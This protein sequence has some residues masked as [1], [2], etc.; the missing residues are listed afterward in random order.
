MDFHHD[1]GEISRKHLKKLGITMPKDCDDWKIYL[2]WLQL[3]QRRLDTDTHYQVYYSKEL[4]QKLET[5]SQED[6]N[7]LSD[8]ENRLCNAE[9][10]TDYM[11][12]LINSIDMKKSDFLLKVWNIYH[13]HLEKKTRKSYKNP[14]VLFFQVRG[15]AAYFID[16]RQHPTGNEWFSRELLNIVYDNWPELLSYRPGVTP[17]L[18]SGEPVNLTDEEIFVL[19]KNGITTLVPFRDGAIFYT[20]AGILASGDSAL[21]GRIADLV[22]NKLGLYQ[23]ELSRN[24]EIGESNSHDSRIDYK[25]I[26]KDGFFVIQETKSKRE[27]ERF[28]VP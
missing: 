9:P 8:I 10:V 7:A 3:K 6:R 21:A 15:N 5:L 20:N 1:L 22:W 19:M 26:E 2:Q 18:E 4:T 23:L 25:L 28:K 11:S 12:K 24:Q 17:A 13:L 16:V 27:I 14:L